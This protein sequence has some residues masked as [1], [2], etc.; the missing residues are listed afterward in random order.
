MYKLIAN[1]L[2][3][4]VGSI[5]F[6]FSHRCMRSDPGRKRFLI[7]L[8][9]LILTLILSVNADHMLVVW[10]SI[11]VSNLLFLCMM[12]HHP[13]WSAAAASAKLA[14]KHLHA[15][16][17]LMLIGI[18]ILC[19]HHQT[20]SLAELVQMPIKNP[21]TLGLL[22][23]FLGSLMQAG[24]WPFQTWLT[25]SLNAPTAV[26]AMMH[27]GVINAGF[28]LLIRLAPLYAQSP[29]LLDGMFA[30]GVISALLGSLYKWMQN[31]L[32][33]TLAFSTLAQ[34][35]FML[36][37]CGIGHFA[38][39]LIHLV[40]HAFF[41]AYL[42]L[43]AASS[44]KS[45]TTPT[46]SISIT[47]FLKVLPH[48]TLASLL[49][50]RLSHIPLQPM[51]SSVVILSIAWITAMH[52]ALSMQVHRASALLNLLFVSAYL[53]LL[54]AMLHASLHFLA[55]ILTQTQPLKIGHV[56][57]IMLMVLVWS[58]IFWM[59]IL[60][61]RRRL[62]RWFLQGYVDILNRTQAH[63]QTITAHRKVYDYATSID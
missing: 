4:A 19:L 20:A 7:T 61:N 28:L 14:E 44:A 47:G 32:K 24:L 2:I 52:L 23:L 49:F 55:P 42:F 3:L 35:G 40:G 16:T 54:G 38:S 36:M 25:S 17:L 53:S 43:S 41:K 37:Q 22:L 45:K 11:F 1:T 46:P 31:D 63:P 10:S 27:G 8:F 59:P 5:V 51:D 60:A 39:A 48:G 33:R 26:S 57:A 12:R 56:L 58:H 62:P 29:G 30:F 34:M 18:I 15:G 9:F 6:A 50:A 13:Q 21:S